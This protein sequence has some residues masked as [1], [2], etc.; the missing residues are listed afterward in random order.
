M[1]EDIFL[2]LLAFALF[3]IAHWLVFHFFTVTHLYRTVQRIA[4][5]FLSIYAL[6]VIVT[7]RILVNDGILLIGLRGRV[8]S[9]LIGCVIY[10][11]L[12]FCY[13]QFYFIVDRGVSVRAMIDLAKLPDGKGTFDDVAATY[14]P[15]VLQRRFDDMVYGGHVTLEQ[16][17]YRLTKK[18]WMFVK[19]FGF[20]KKFLRLYP[21]G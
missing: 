8:M 16:G 14:V 13:L 20:C 19:V 6:L 1:T 15:A 4:S 2:C 10:V 3:L 5:I 12:Y 7:P 21:G 17:T 18:G 9:F 11:L